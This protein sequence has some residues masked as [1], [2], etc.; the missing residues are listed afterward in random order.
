MSALGLA[1]VITAGATY[2]IDWY[3]H[4]LIRSNADLI[5]FLP[6]GSSTRFFVDVALLRRAGILKLSS[7]GGLGEDPEF[8]RFQ[9]ET[10]F[11]YRRDLD[12]LGGSFEG[13]RVNFVVRGRFARRDLWQYAAARGGT[14]NENVCRMP[15]STPGRWASF[16]LVQPDVLALWLGPR[17]SEEAP[18]LDAKAEGGG[19]SP[20]P[21]PIWFEPS[22]ELL[23]HP[24]DLPL[25]LQIF[26]ISLQSASPVILSLG[27][28]GEDE[29][30][31]FLLKLDAQFPNASAADTIRKQLEL[32]TKSLSLAL[33]KQNLRSDPK[34][35]AGLL[36][37]GT[38]QASDRHMFGRW[39]IRP[40][41]LRSLE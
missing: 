36:A 7:K 35:F 40:E 32:E 10:H 23:Q 1:A 25:P 11:D 18:H 39:P 41:L 9:Q 22:H 28:A 21:D 4:R 15:A 29:G 14:C 20:S 24:A 30:G 33:A 13:D 2:S 37:S 12:A 31:A 38:F 17:P 6:E 16:A 34:D 5:A 3:R 26:A 27:A 8:R 19:V